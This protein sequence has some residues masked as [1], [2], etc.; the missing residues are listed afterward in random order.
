MRY[1]DAVDDLAREVDHH[2]PQDVGDGGGLGQRSRPPAT[3]AAVPVAGSRGIDRSGDG[4]RPKLHAAAAEG[5][6]RLSLRAHLSAL[7]TV[8]Q[9]VT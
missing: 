1:V 6:F 8:S 4:S 9:N 5:A 7:W 2:H 3:A